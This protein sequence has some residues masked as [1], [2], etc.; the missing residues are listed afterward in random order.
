[1]TRPGGITD[2][3]WALVRR[4]HG[5]AFRSS[6]HFAVAS[7]DQEGRPHV[8]PIGSVLLLEKGRGIYFEEFTRKL[9]HHLR[10]NDRI[11]VLAVNSGRWFWLASLFTG[12]FQRPPAVRLHG[13]AGE[14]REATEGEL[15]L[16]DRRLGRLRPLRGYRLLWGDM[17]TV[18]ELFFHAVDP[19][20]LGEMTRGHWEGTG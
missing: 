15:A 18:R 7:V 12:R 13:R 10:E 17:S 3:E 11:S 2:R 6:F 4:I 8:S 5:E 16:L 20:H 1:M 9:P 14:R 19:V